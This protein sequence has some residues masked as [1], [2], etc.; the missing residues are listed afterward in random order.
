MGLRVLPLLPL[1]LGCKNIGHVYWVQV[2]L[3]IISTAY[4][5]D[6]YPGLG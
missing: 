3:L 5:V 1:A 4:L 2:C 6:D